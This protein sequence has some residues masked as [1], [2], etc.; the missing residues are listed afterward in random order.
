MEDDP[1]MYTEFH[2]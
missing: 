2:S 1:D